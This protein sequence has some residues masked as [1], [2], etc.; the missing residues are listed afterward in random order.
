MLVDEAGCDLVKQFPDADQNLQ[1]GLDLDGEQNHDDQPHDYVRKSG[2]WEVLEPGDKGDIEAASEND[3]QP[4]IEMGPWKETAGTTVGVR[5]TEKADQDGAEI[6]GR[7]KFV[8]G[9][10]VGD[11]IGQKA[12]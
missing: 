8:V 9:L 3:S 11:D 7:G 6:R 12:C 4:P 10:I 1:A 2:A 5:H